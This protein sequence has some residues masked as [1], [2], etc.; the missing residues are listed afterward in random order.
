MDPD[1]GAR[2]LY[3]VLLGGYLFLML[4]GGGLAL[5]RF[6]RSLIVWGL[7]IGGL[8]FGYFVF[9]DEIQSPTA[10]VAVVGDEIVLRRAR[11]GHFHAEAEVNGRPIR[12]IVDTGAT[13]V[14]L[15]RDD[16][17]AAGI[18]TGAL[19]YIGRARTANGIVRTAPV[20]LESLAL[21][22]RVDADVRATVSEGEMGVSLLGM[23]YL[24]RFSRIEIAG[25]EMRLVP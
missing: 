9:V 8:A 24:D 4:V 16:A 17:A 10:T 15:S 11:D 20:R 5:G 3:L 13:E 21:G 18:D 23:A 1:T 6:L 25:D 12:F 2:S 7:L 22:E 14:V 19:H